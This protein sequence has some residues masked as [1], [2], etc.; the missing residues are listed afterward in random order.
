MLL[1]GRQSYDVSLYLIIINSWNAFNNNNY[2][3]TRFYIFFIFFSYLINSLAPPSLKTSHAAF[4]QLIE[5]KLCQN[6]KSD[7]W[8]LSSCLFGVCLPT[9]TFSLASAC[10]YFFL[11]AL[12]YSP[13]PGGGE[14]GG[15]KKSEACVPLPSP[16][17]RVYDCA[18]RPRY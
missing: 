5:K 10:S 15:K 3:I 17:R 1:T 11:A 8:L 13:S 4:F 16:S 6:G 7:P 2:K 18:W 9:F 12:I 14:R